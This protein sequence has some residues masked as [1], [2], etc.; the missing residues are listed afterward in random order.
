MKGNPMK[1][2]AT[3]FASLSL[4]AVLAGVDV[5]DLDQGMR[6]GDS[7][8]GMM[9]GRCGDGVCV[10]QCGENI[11]TCPQDCLGSGS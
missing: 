7:E 1:I 3:L 8:A 5:Q 9:C 4:T 6:S 11:L 10:K 2:V